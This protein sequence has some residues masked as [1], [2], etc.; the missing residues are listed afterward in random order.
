MKF[1]SVNLV[2]W[3]LRFGRLSYIMGIFK[4]IFE[5]K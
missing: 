2:K 5:I 3:I 1:K 4:D